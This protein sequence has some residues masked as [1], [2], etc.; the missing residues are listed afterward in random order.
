MAS[1]VADFHE[2]MERSDINTFER[3]RQQVVGREKEPMKRLSLLF[4]FAAGPLAQD[5]RVVSGRPLLEVAN[6]LE[7]K[8][9]TPVHYEEP[10]WTEQDAAADSLG[11]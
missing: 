6:K 11:A 3:E 4:L 7:A 5:Q 8:W 10:V 1:W 2:W 9:A